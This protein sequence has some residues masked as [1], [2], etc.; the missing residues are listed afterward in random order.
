MP[1]LPNAFDHSRPRLII[2]RDNDRRNR[3]IVEQHGAKLAA[4]GAHF[5]AYTMPR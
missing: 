2:V 5:V 1:W 4:T 3:A